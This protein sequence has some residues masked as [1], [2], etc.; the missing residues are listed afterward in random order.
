MI[1]GIILAGGHLKDKNL[2]KSN[3]VFRGKT[4]IERIVE[5][6]AKSKYVS[7][8]IVIAYSEGLSKLPE[9]KKALLKAEIPAGEDLIGRIFTAL[10]EASNE[11][12]LIIP[13][14]VPFVDERVIDGFIEECLKEENDAYYPI[15]KKEVIEE[16]FP[17]T[18]RTYGKLKEGTFTGGNLFL[19]KKSLFYRN[20]RFIEDI[21]N[22]RKSAYKMARVAGA[23]IFLKGIFGTL[24]VRD[25]EK[26]VSKL[27]ENARLKAVETRFPEIG[28]DVDKEEDLLFLK[29]YEEGNVH[30]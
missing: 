19:I 2:P 6:L 25:A 13:V 7:E 4:L 5:A 26:R 30:A 10:D 28:I 1:T 12:I 18:K 23:K 14:D 3:I 20:R 16:A 15:I 9:D 27:F 21:Y 29:K 8:I 22:A 24:T 11:F 17:E